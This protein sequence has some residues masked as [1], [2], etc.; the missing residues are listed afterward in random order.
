MK[1][2]K[3]GAA[4]RLAWVTAAVIAAALLLLPRE[5]Q[6]PVQEKAED[7]PTPPA[8]SVAGNGQRME[9]DCQIIQTM[10]FSRCGHSVTRRV[11]APEALAGEGFEA[12]RA[13]YD[14]WSIESF[15]P[16]NV[17]M[18][19][20]IDLFCPMHAVLSVNDAGEAVLTK[21]VYGDGMAVEKT[22][23]LTLADFEPEDRQ[24][25]L[26]GIGF[27]SKEAAETWLAERKQRSENRAQSTD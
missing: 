15:S 4:F 20:E 22:Y 25:L 2:T 3:W 12:A 27:D 7:L 1:K 26:R 16:E 19:R 14:A 21:N 5:A 13:Y 17:T 9:K 23:A 18:Q 10:A 6:A 24:A 11:S 8:A